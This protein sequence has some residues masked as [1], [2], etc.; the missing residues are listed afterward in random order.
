MREIMGYNRCDDTIDKRKWI[1]N[2]EV[3][4]DRAAS[5]IGETRNFT[6]ELVWGA[7]ITYYRGKMGELRVVV[8]Y[9]THKR[10]GPKFNET[11]YNKTFLHLRIMREHSYP[12]KLYYN[13]LCNKLKMDI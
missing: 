6:I 4:F 11:V 3:D 10:A 8:A 1:E 5:L 9:C 13:Y 12:L 7:W 2:R